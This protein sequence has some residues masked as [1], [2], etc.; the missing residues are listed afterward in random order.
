MNA[1]GIV[2]VFGH[3]VV[4]GF[5]SEVELA[6][7]KF[8]RVE[9]PEIERESW[10]TIESYDAW[11]KLLGGASV[12]SV[13]PCSEELARSRAARGGVTN[14][15]GPTQIRPKREKVLALT[16][17]VS[18]YDAK[19]GEDEPLDDTS[20]E[21][22][23]AYGDAGDSYDE[24]SPVA[25]ILFCP[26]C[27]MQH[28]DAP[29]LEKGWDNPP[30]RSHLCGGCGHI[31]R[32]ADVPTVGVDTIWTYSSNDSHPPIR[33][34]ANGLVPVPATTIEEVNEALA[35]NAV[36]D[37]SFP[38]DQ[39]VS[40]GENDG[41]AEPDPMPFQPAEVRAGICGSCRGMTNR[42]CP[43]CWRETGR[44]LY[45]CGAEG[46]TAV[47]AAEYHEPRAVVSSSA[48]DGTTAAGAGLDALH[49]RDQP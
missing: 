4:A 21:I 23:R 16:G 18:E 10:D 5:V 12:F 49:H 11:S 14:P 44:S 24:P 37:P 6:G 28:I 20:E 1:W 48:S 22:E 34:W 42:L 27:G 25:M 40:H 26:S 8:L 45:V 31:W 35:A 15:A 7:T 38:F 2:E 30:H 9:V 43:Q 33:G 39:V 3:Q 46:C 13:T 29:D 36:R 32:P 19:E 41:D 47:H 17:A